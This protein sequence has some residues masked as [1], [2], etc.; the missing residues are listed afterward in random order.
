MGTKVLIIAEL[1]KERTYIESV[2]CGSNHVLCD[3]WLEENDFL[4]IPNVEGKCLTFKGYYEMETLSAK[5]SPQPSFPNEIVSRF[6][7]SDLPPINQVES[8]V[9]IPADE[10]RGHGTET[11]YGRRDHRAFAHHRD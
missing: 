11:V 2:I 1:Q 5:L 4:R 7:S 3:I 6:M 10:R 8:G 9:R